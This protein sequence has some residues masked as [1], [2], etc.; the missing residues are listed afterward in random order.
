MSKYVW[1]CLIFI[2][3]SGFAEGDE[4]NPL[5]F[6]P[7]EPAARY[8]DNELVVKLH[9][10]VAFNWSAFAKFE[11]LAKQFGVVS[12]EK[13]FP[14]L[15]PGIKPEIDRIYLLRFEVQK[16]NLCEIKN[17][18]E[19]SP[20]IEDVDFNY[21]RRPCTEQIKPNDARFSEQ[22]NLLAIRMS[23]AWPLNSGS[24][25]LI[26]AIVDSGVDLLHEDLVDQLWRNPGEIAD[27]GIDDDG[28]GYVDDVVGWDF[29]DAPTLDGTGD[30]TRRDNDPSDESGH[31]THVAGIACAKTNNGIGIAGISWNCR[32]MPLRAGFNVASGGAFLQDDDVAS[33]IVYAADNGSTRLNDGSRGCIKVI[34][35]SWGDLSNA[36]VI[37]D[38]VNYAYQ[39]GCVL[40]A[41]AGNSS[42]TFV[43][44]PAALPNVISVGATDQNHQIA[45]MSNYGEG[46]DLFAPGTSIL[47]TQIN[48]GYNTMS[49]TSMAAPHVSGVA[50]LILSKYPGLTNDDLRNILISSSRRQ[51][52][53]TSVSIVDA[54][55]ALASRL[56]LCAKIQVDLGSCENSEI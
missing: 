32:L 8:T 55:K 4:T 11:T 35:M 49:G 33:A 5:F 56:D 30:Y 52:G 34:N 47:S 18:L 26:I 44:Y 14:T 38:A 31:G 36:F 39:H 28:N 37:S 17:S 25:D 2:L 42:D 20:L 48:G 19:Q 24:K 43:L 45:S 9:S 41:S 16:S 51:L 1:F 21:L 10:E 15:G 50:G 54:A 40:V 22:W 53:K 12:I 27:N 46:V 13:I 7:N 3:F 29:S 23:T 6:A